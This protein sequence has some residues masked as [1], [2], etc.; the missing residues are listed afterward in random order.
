L[1]EPFGALDPITRRE[2]QEEFKNLETFLHKTMVLVSHDVFEAFDLGDRVCLMDAGKVQ[3]IDTAKKL[4]FQPENNFVKNFFKAN[5]FQLELKVL[6]LEDVLSVLPSP[7]RQDGPVVDF[8]QSETLLDVLEHL[9]NISAENPI[10]NIIDGSEQSIAKTIYE[11]IL[12][13]FHKVKNKIRHE[14]L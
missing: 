5:R 3:Q 13:A 6:T 12:T 2:V 11:D 7:G 1:D 10:V 9:E 8:K 4:I 14:G